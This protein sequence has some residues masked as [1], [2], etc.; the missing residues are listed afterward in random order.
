MSV[1]VKLLS[2]LLVLTAV[3]GLAA[4]GGSPKQPS[5]DT[6]KPSGEGKATAAAGLSGIKIRV[7]VDG[8]VL[9]ATLIDNA[10]TRSLIDMFP[11][12]VR[13]ADLYSREMCYHFPDPLPADEAQRSGYE[14]GDLSYWTPGRSLVIFYK[15]NGEVISNLQKIG[16]FDSSVGMFEKTG[17]VDVRFE[18]MDK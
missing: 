5:A 2:I 13:M 15:Q 17:D 10:T 18:L 9:T 1:Q 4:C 11:L 7:T 12:T 8:D 6:A 16:H 3:F 14:V